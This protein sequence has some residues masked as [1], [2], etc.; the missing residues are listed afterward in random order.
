MN[1]Q[2]KFSHLLKKSENKACYYDFNTSSSRNEELYRLFVHNILYANTN[3]EEALPETSDNHSYPLP[4]WGIETSLPR[5]WYGY[6]HTTVRPST[7]Q[8]SLELKV[9]LH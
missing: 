1:K 6:K 8:L 3:M 4:Q 2:I 9:R 7:L 5:W